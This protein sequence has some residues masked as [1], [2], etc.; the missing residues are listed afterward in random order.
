MGLLSA[1]IFLKVS[2]KRAS[3]ANTYTNTTYAACRN[4]NP[5]RGPDT[6][7]MATTACISMSERRHACHHVNTTIKGSVSWGRCARS[8]MSVDVSVCSIWRGSVRKE[9]RVPMLTCGG[10]RICLGRPCGPRRPRRSWNTNGHSSERN[11]SGRRSASASGG[12]NEGV[13]AGSCGA[14]TVGAEGVRILSEISSFVYLCLIPHWF[15]LAGYSAW[16]SSEKLLYLHN[17]PYCGTRS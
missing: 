6:A 16:R 13:E 17:L 3:N 7:P 9:R 8:G 4:A 12:A 14:G 2:A 10:R 1:N 15:G 11:K 5:S